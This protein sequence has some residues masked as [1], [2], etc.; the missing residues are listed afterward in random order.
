VSTVPFLEGERFQGCDFAREK[1]EIEHVPRPEIL[2]M[3]KNCLL[4]KEE[5]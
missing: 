1:I 2:S 5:K 4:S 3:V